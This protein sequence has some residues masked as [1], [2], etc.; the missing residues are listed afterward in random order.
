MTKIRRMNNL[1]KADGRTLIVAMDHGSNAGAPHG[2][3]DPG[4]TIS[5][6]KA[7]GA[8]AVIVNYG[9]A[10]K[11][12]KELAGLGLIL[13]MDLSPSLL[14]QGHASTL[15]YGVEQALEVAAD[16]VIINAGPG[17]GVEEITHPN[18]A[19]IAAECSRWGIPVIAEPSPGGFDSDPEIRTLENISLASRIACELG[20]DMIKTIYKPGFERVVQDCFVP[21]VVLG[22]SKTN[23][24]QAFLA[25]IKEAIDAGAAGVAIGRN[26]W[27]YE[28]PTKMTKALAIIVHENKTVDDAMAILRG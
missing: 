16:A 9:V 4:E 3:V 13:R 11:F 28:D 25:S 27:G 1:L 14:G 8:D 7:G 21:V 6:V 26:I 5:K 19:K 20:A 12:A 17:T 23:D 22:G 15:I 18:L 2:L 10:K 24:Y